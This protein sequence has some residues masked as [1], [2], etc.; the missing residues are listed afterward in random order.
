MDP[1]AFLRDS[2]IPLRLSAIDQDG[3]PVIC[4]LWYLYREGA[5]Y[6]VSH[7]N[8]K[9]IQ[10]LKE[11]SECG[12]EIAVNDIPY[13]GVR[14]K[15]VATLSSDSEGLLLGKLIDRYLGDSNQPLA[16]WLLSRKADEI[17]ICLQPKT[18]SSWDFSERMSDS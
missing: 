18:L 16:N 4:S 3:F 7:R 10:L 8:A 13:R 14:G 12:F 2:L 11:R 15:A 6:C 9:M 17:A 5:L 1:S